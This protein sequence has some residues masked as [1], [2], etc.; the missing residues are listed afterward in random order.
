MVIPNI[1]CVSWN[2]PTNSIMRRWREHVPAGFIALDILSVKDM[3]DKLSFCCTT[4]I[5]I[6]QLWIVGH[7][8]PLGQYIGQDEVTLGRIEIFQ[9][10]LSRLVCLF[11]KCA[12]PPPMVTM[13]GCKV[14]RN[15]QLLL[16][17]ENI[18]HVAVRGYFDITDPYLQLQGHSQTA[19]PLSRDPRCGQR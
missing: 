12:S 3:A 9:S 19:E 8:G 10:D 14:G 1:C 18:L 5:T 17:L 2:D 16:A 13:C 7:G 15:F 11:N 4:G 6:G